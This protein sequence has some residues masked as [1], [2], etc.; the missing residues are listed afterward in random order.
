MAVHPAYQRKGV[1]QL[2]LRHQ[3]DQI[4]D[5][6]AVQLESSPEGQGLYRKVGFEVFTTFE[7]KG[8]MTIPVMLKNYNKAI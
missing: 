5:G 4:P 3:L 1:G 8:G 7:I 2:L 6:L